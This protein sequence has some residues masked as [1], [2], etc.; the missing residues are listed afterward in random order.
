MQHSQHAGHRH[1]QACHTADAGA[2]QRALGHV[3]GHKE[4]V[5]EEPGA[6]VVPRHAPRPHLDGAHRQA[7]A[8]E[9]GVREVA[10]PVEQHD[11]LHGHEAG[12]LGEVKELQGRDDEVVADEQGTEEVPCAPQGGVGVH[13]HARNGVLQPA[14]GCAVLGGLT[15]PAAATARPP[16]SALVPRGRADCIQHHRVGVGEPAPLG[17]HPCWP[18]AKAQLASGIARSHRLVALRCLRRLVHVRNSAVLI[19]RLWQRRLV[20]RVQRHHGNEPVGKRRRHPTH[21][22][23][24]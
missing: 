20:H 3:Q 23:K 4:Q 12:P 1:V 13:D 6:E 5:E 10:E 8:R 18:H 7:V 11:P 21:R 22:R 19:A 16:V 2:A 17:L 9:Q 24:R 15:M 14:R